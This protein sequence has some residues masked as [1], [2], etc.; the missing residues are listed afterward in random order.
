MLLYLLTKNTENLNYYLLL[1]AQKFRSN[2]MQFCYKYHHH[3]NVID[4]IKA[5]TKYHLIAGFVL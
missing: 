2:T 3:H 5:A 4:R 1:T